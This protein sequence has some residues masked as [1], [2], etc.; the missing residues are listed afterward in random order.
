MKKTFSIITT[1]LLVVFL[2]SALFTMVGCTPSTGD[3]AKN[4]TENQKLPVTAFN[5]AFAVEASG[6]AVV[7]PHKG[8]VQ[9][10]WTDDYLSNEWWDLALASGK[11]QSWNYCSVVYTGCG[12]NKNSKR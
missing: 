1:V 8:F 2:I 3:A 6:G 5:K 12:W 11:N 4:E 7:N 10:A 9:Y